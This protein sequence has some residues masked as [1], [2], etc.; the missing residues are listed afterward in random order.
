MALLFVFLFEVSSITPKPVSCEVIGSVKNADLLP[1]VE[2]IGGLCNWFSLI[3]GNRFLP[4]SIFME[5]V[6]CKLIFRDSTF[7]L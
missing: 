4:N 5:E 7:W 1:S 6:G 3:F 2:A